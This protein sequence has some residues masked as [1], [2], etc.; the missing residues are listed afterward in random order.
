M[1]R[2]LAQF[3]TLCPGRPRAVRVAD[4]KSRRQPLPRLASGYGASRTS[5]DVRC[6]AGIGG[7]ADIAALS[8][9]VAENKIVAAPVPSGR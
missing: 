6:R 9:D 7:V 3:P 2:I 4:F 8:A 1:G 5:D